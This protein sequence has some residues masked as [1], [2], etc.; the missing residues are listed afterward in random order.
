MKGLQ[1]NGIRERLEVALEKTLLPLIDLYTRSR[2]GLSL[3]LKNRAGRRMDRI[4]RRYPEI[5][6]DRSKE[7]IQMKTLELT[8]IAIMRFLD[9]EGF[10]HCA[11]CPERKPLRRLGDDFFCPAHHAAELKNQKAPQPQA[12]GAP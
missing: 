9:R 12:V 7:Y 11:R 4:A 10:V 8:A 6:I 1:M 2:N 3:Y 5:Y